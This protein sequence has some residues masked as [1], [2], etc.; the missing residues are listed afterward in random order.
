MSAI[1]YMLDLLWISALSKTENPVEKLDHFKAE[2]LSKVPIDP[3]FPEIT[4][5]I[6][7]CI[8]TQFSRLKVRM[9]DN[10]P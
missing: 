6:S 10:I 3:D 4:D 1:E 8:E 7:A 9:I 2:A 5:I